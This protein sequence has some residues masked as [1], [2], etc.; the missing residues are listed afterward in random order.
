MV[1]RRVYF[2][3]AVI[4]FIVFFL[5]QFSVVAVEIWNDYDENSYVRDVNQLPGKDDAYQ[6]T[7]QSGENAGRMAAYIGETEGSVGN[8]VKTWALYSKRGLKTYA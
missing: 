7:A 5:F 3:I 2:T 8:M 1:S 4:M 6:A